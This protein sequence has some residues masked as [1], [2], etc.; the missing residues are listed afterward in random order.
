MGELSQHKVV[1]SSLPI[2]KLAGKV[3]RSSSWQ[4][5]LLGG[6]DDWN[7]LLNEQQFSE[8]LYSAK[9]YVS[10]KC[11]KLETALVQA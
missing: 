10:T 5:T 11:S 1:R 8:C 2:C 6:N 3:G 9:A 7:F 4:S